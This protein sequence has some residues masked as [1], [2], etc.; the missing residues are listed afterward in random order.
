M[1]NF[2]IQDMMEGQMNRAR[3]KK[4]KD[5]GMLEEIEKEMER[6]AI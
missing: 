2:L 6:K 3:Q 1:A 4:E 5:D